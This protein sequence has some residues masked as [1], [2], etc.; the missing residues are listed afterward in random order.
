MVLVGF[1]EVVVAGKS[2]VGLEEAAV[3]KLKL[4]GGMG[5]AE[6]MRISKYLGYLMDDIEAEKVAEGSPGPKLWLVVEDRKLDVGRE[7]VADMAHDLAVEDMLYNVEDSDS[8]VDF[9]LRFGSR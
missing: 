2:I 7:A 5:F 1:L 4:V 8:V 9:E 6:D 3:R